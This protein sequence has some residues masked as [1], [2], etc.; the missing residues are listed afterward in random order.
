MFENAHMSNK[1]VESNF[2]YSEFNIKHF[3]LNLN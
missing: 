1:S 2:L 3:K